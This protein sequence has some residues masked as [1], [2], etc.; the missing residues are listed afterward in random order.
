MQEVEEVA[1][2]GVISDKIVETAVEKTQQTHKALLKV[3]FTP[4]AYKRKDQTGLTLFHCCAALGIEWA[5]RNFQLS[6]SQII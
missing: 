2:T 4:S 3:A 1:K 6:Q 5:V